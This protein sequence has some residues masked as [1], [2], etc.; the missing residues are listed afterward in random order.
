MAVLLEVGNEVID[1]HMLPTLAL[2]DCSIHV[3]L[4]QQG[5]HNG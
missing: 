1:L 2:L 4:P 5:F 3:P